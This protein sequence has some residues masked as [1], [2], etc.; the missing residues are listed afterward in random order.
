MKTNPFILFLRISRPF[1]LAGSFLLYALGVGIARYL[2]KNLDWDVILIGLAWIFSMQLA[3]H[4]LNE[5]FDA[6]ADARNPNRTPFSGGSGALGAGEGK[7]P[8]WVALLAAAVMLTAVAILS[9]GLVRTERLTPPTVLMM[10]LI[11]LAG[12]FYS[13]PPLRLA[14]SGYGE[15][16]TSIVV[17]NLVPAFAFLLLAGEVHRL[18]AMSTFPLTSL[19]MAMLLALELP[20]YASD[21]KNEKHNLLVRIGWKDGMALHNIFIL[22]A[23]ALLGL[24]TLFGFPSSIALPAFVPLPLGLLQIWYMRR[25]AAGAKPNWVALTLGAVMLFGS[26]AYLLT[27]AFWVR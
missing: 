2:G 19:H 8:R 15:L 13:V 3:V 9:L 14:T 25:I 7:L 5:Y 4:Y 24:A 11:F 22:S 6:P 1:F 27:Y 20:D 12:F 21:T 26:V 18:L 17:A 16:T 23:F 10:A